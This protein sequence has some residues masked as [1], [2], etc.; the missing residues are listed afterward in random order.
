MI[1]ILLISQPL[2]WEELELSSLK[3]HSSQTQP[4][5]GLGMTT[6]SSVEISIN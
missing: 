4:P 6:P 3:Q 2:R 1:G 5:R